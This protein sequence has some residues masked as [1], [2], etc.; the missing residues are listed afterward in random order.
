MKLKADPASMRRKQG[1]LLESNSPNSRLLTDF[2]DLQHPL[3]QLAERID[4]SSFESQWQ[5]CFSS[6]SGPHAAPTRLAAGLLMLKHME[7]LSDERLI[8]S[9]VCNPY[10]QYFCG[11]I[12]FQHQPPINPI[13]MGRW[14]RQLGEEGMEYLLTTV[15]DSAL[16]MG[17]VKADVS[18]TRMC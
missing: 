11:E 14:R 18:G 15:L 1:Q 6:A 5:A 4:W 16:K 8:E 13:T 3:V 12:H 17:T 9:W 7:G 2:I 10:Y